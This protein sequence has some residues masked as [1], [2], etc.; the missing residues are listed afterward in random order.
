MFENYI[1]S[2]TLHGVVFL[3]FLALDQVYFSE[4]APAYEL[5]DFE[6]FEH[7]CLFAL[8]FVVK[9]HWLAALFLH[10][11]VFVSLIEPLY[12]RL[13]AHSLLLML[14]VLHDAV[15]IEYS[16][17]LL[18]GNWVNLHPIHLGLHLCLLH[19]FVRH[20]V[21]LVQSREV[22]RQPVV[23]LLHIFLSCNEITKR[24]LLADAENP[25]VVFVKSNVWQFYGLKEG[26]S[27][28]KSGYKYTKIKTYISQVTL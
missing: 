21:L 5:D 11:S 27:P 17:W 2:N 19:L 25:E 16:V 18:Y 10:G 26:V 20:Q 12:T 6:I 13:S 22:Q 4:C 28:I 9:M 3:V 24:F 15:S 14:D 7:S 23:T 1:F 8:V